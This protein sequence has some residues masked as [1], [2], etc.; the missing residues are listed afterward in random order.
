MSK[1]SDLDLQLREIQEAM[2]EPP[3]PDEYLDMMLHDLEM[4]A[5]EMLSISEAPQGL[6]RMLANDTRWFGALL[7]MHLVSDRLTKH[8]TREPGRLRIVGQ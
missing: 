7:A 6:D 1:L 5:K 2:Q 4:V 3:G 8:V